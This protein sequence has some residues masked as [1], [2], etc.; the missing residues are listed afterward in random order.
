MDGLK[1]DLRIYVVVSG[2]NHGSLTAHIC[3]EG[4]ARFCT[5]PYEKPSK[6]NM[7]KVFM[8]LTNYS[9]NKTSDKFV[10]ETKIRNINEPNN[11]SKR[12]LTALFKQI[13]DPNMVSEI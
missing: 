3:Q 8:H 6:S 5:E 9:L 12:T 1:F 13:G 7:K 11:G 2:I 4:L 10:D